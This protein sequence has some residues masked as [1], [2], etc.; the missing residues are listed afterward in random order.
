MRGEMWGQ[1]DTLL[2]WVLSCSVPTALS[3]VGILPPRH[4]SCEDH[5]AGVHQGTD[6]LGTVM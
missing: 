3:V 4:A 5:C 6:A 1:S 2:H